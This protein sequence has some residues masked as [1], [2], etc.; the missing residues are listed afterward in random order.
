MSL[1][2]VLHGFTI[3]HLADYL[4]QVPVLRPNLSGEDVGTS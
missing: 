1:R 4:E 3:I 2:L